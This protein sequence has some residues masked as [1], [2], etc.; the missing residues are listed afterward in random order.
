[1]IQQLDLSEL[2][3][4]SVD[5][6]IEIAQTIWD[7]IAAQPTAAL[8]TELQRQELERRLADHL[9]NPTDVV[10]WEQVKAQALARARK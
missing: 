3:S 9:A 6:R 8:P 1:M 4:M 2:H 10:P 7:S 5:D